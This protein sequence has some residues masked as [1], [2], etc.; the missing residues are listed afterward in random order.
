MIDNTDVTSKAEC[1]GG[2]HGPDSLPE[3]MKFFDP[4]LKIG[5]LI[6]VAGFVVVSVYYGS[7]VKIWEI[8]I[9]QGKVFSFFTYASISYSTVTLLYLLF[10][11]FLWIRYKP[12][13]A[14][15]YAPLPKVSV[16]IPAYNEG[17]LVEKAIK[18][19]IES[20]YP[21]D[22]LEVIC[23][24][25]GSKDDTFLYMQ[26]AR[27]RY[28][29]NVELIKLPRNM[30]KRHALYNGFKKAKG[31][32]FVTIDSDSIIEKGALHNIVAPFLKSERIGAVAGNVKVLNRYEGIIPRMLGVSFILSFDFTRACQ[33]TYGAVLCCPG[34]FSAYR[35]DIVRQVEEQW[36]HEIFLGEV[37][38]YGED[39][40]L[41]NMVLR[42][43]FYTI[44]QN[45][46]VVHTQV[47]TTY[48]KLTR[49][50]LRWERSNIR[51]SII[52]ST[53][54]MRRYR[55]RHRILPFVNF[56]IVNLRYPFQY[57]A[58]MF[59]FINLAIYPANIFRYLSVVGLISFL[60]ML[61]YIRAEKN[62]D[63]IYG[64]LYSYVSIFT[65]QWIFPYAFATLKSKSWMTR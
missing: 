7:F 48:H 13:T 52:L 47:P 5:I 15:Q 63:F 56:V 23:V 61:Y 21:G 18:A 42:K 12:Y 49:M 53:F 25:D 24:D 43:G 41:T 4:V 64:I 51:E 44:Y 6:V 39:R 40:A 35:A 65:L 2:S 34:A 20:G 30:G 3:K 33:S 19:A 37:C 50:Y 54:I 22:R 55:E 59:L 46:A 57:Y 36:L 26:K 38:T 1:S 10:R 14:A 60:Y 58:I 62:S 17:A 31:G 45:N 28:P 32:I 27:A 9:A 8:T 16:I 11:T 29:D